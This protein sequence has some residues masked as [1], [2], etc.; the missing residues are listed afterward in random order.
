MDLRQYTLV[1]APKRMKLSKIIKAD[2]RRQ[3]TSFASNYP[4]FRTEKRRV[5]EESQTE[6]DA[7]A[8]CCY[9]VSA[10]KKV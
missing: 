3:L 2:K 10:S 9:T 5:D 8:Y 1:F 7:Y 4:I 6:I